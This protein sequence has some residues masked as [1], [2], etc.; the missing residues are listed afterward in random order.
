MYSKSEHDDRLA[1]NKVFV[2]QCRQ[3]FSVLGAQ[4]TFGNST[5]CN[6]LSPQK[7]STVFQSVLEVFSLAI[8][9]TTG[10]RNIN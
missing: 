2:L 1:R 3:V 6:L 8:K 5:R 9:Y 7:H 10:K 4:N